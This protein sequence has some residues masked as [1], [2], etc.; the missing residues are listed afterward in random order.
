VTPRFCKTGRQPEPG[1]SAALK[2]AALA[3]SVLLLATLGAGC[4]R[5]GALEPPPGARVVSPAQAQASP[6]SDFGSGPS[7]RPDRR[8]DV[9][10]TPRDPLAPAIPQMTPGQVQQIQNLPVGPQTVS[11]GSAGLRTTP[12][13]PRRS[14]P[15]ERGFILDPLL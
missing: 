10:D 6:A 15:P 5:R 8:L 7:F 3:L 2:P 4:G 11:A 12:R 13:D 14:P 1:A 9:G